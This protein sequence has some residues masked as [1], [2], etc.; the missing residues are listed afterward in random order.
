MLRIIRKTVPSKRSAHL[1]D[2]LRT[3]TDSP[4]AKSSQ[5]QLEGAED[6]SAPKKRAL[7]QSPCGH[8]VQWPVVHRRRRAA[9]AVRF[10]GSRGRRRSVQQELFQRDAGFPEFKI[11]MK[12][13]L[14]PAGSC[15]RRSRVSHGGRPRRK[16][17][18]LGC[19]RRWLSGQSLR[20][21]PRAS[22]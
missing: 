10:G 18:T 7:T 6:S 2:K 11:V 19:R 17:A 22:R 16:R 4:E 5:A 21:W 3:L 14:L 9:G 12:R 15:L 1:L 20:R 8:Q 13:I